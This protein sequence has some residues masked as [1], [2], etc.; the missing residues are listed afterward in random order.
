M[1]LLDLWLPILLSAVAVFFVSFL[2]HMV[3]KYHRSDI[4]SVPNEDAAMDAVRTWNLPPGQYMF[5]HGGG[6]EAMKDPAFIKKFET[7][8]V[9]HFTVYP[10]SKLT[11]TPQLIRWFIFTVVVSLFAAYIAARAVGPGAEYL[12]VFRFAGA[13]AFFCYA[14]ADWQNTIWWGR[15]VSTTVKNTIDGLIYALVTAGIFGWLWP[16]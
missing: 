15:K 10:Q 14:V 3:L 8:P 2:L 4:A 5:P 1:N 9:A 12:E 7:G 16:N 6:P 11:M 13:T